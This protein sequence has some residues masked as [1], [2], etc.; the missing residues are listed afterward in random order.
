MKEKSQQFRLGCLVGAKG[1]IPPCR[2]RHL[3]SL[4]LSARL[5]SSLRTLPSSSPKHRIQPQLWL[6]VVTLQPRRRK[7][8][9]AICSQPHHSGIRFPP[10]GFILANTLLFS[11]ST[12]SEM[13]QCSRTSFIGD[14]TSGLKTVVTIS[15]FTEK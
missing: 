13:Q 7:K 2:S 12:A 1:N 3:T 14:I 5:P 11:R 15:S 6:W 8:S 4:V 10:Q 9:E